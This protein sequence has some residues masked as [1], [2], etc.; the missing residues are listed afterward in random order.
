[1]KTSNS[2]NGGKSNGVAARRY[3]ESVKQLREILGDDVLLLRCKL[4]TKKPAGA[5]GKLTVA[6]MTPDYLKKLSNGNAGVALG[7]KS[8]NLIAVDVDDDSLVESYLAANPSWNDTLQTHGARGRVFWFRMAGDYPAK[9]VKLKTHSGDDCGEF[10]SNGSQSIIRGIHPNGN[11]YQVL[12]MVKPLVVDFASIVWPVEISNPPRLEAKL[13]V[14][15]TERQSYGVTESQ[16]HRETDV[17]DD[18]DA[19]L[20]ASL[21]VSK[22]LSSHFVGAS[23]SQPA[24]IQKKSVDFSKLTLADAVALAMPDRIHQNNEWLFILGRAV[25]RLESNSGQPFTPAQLR[26]VFNEWHSQAQPYLRKELTRDDYLIQFM[27]AYQSA[28]IPLGEDGVKMA[29]KRAQE[30]PLPPEAI[31]HFEDADKRLL[32]ALCRELQ[33]IHGQQPFFLSARTVQQL[34]KLESHIE[35]ARWLRSFCVLKI[36][37]E[38]EKGKGDRA[39][40]YRFNFANN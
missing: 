33:I 13:P 35:P 5:W 34:F 25:K 9:T 6:S 40:R 29:W 7:A 32:V 16:S 15:D 17:T 37:D 11:Q 3:F 10:R 30:N 22:A 20:Y 23:N 21:P 24:P 18:T 39:S 2:I 12:N 38:V 19:I 26:E 36:L 14:N 31:N 27:N 28:K 4:Q 1:M 8:G